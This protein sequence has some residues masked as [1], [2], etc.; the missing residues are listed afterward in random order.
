M[1]RGATN[2]PL[3]DIARAHVDKAI[4]VQRYV[5]TIKRGRAMVVSGHLVFVQY[6]KSIPGQQSVT[7]RLTPPM[8]HTQFASICRYYVLHYRE[9]G[10][11]WKII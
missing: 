3:G 2:H 4:I 1:I 7:P 6:R 10:G 5:P 11:G 9:G 8:S